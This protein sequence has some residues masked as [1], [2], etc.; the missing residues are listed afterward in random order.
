MREF[1]REPALDAARE[2]GLVEALD[3][4][5]EACLE[6]ALEEGCE[7][8]AEARE[9]RPDKGKSLKGEVDL[10]ADLEL[11]C[12]PMFASFR[13]TGILESEPLRVEVSDVSE[14][15]SE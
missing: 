13:R 3:V 7:A 1:G 14:I 6:L 5:R 8:T 4:E 2:S 11:D 10:E 15:G 9:L 12:E